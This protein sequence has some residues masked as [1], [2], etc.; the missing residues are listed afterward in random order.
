MLLLN[1]LASLSYAGNQVWKIGHVRPIDSSIDKDIRGLTKEISE[2]TDGQ[3]NFEVYPASKL[4]DYSLV[5]ERCSFGEVEM[6][7]GPF[8][9]T[10]DRRLALPATPYLVKNWSEAKRVFAHDNLLMKKMAVYLEQQNIKLL[11]GWPV[12]FGG[13]LTT[14]KPIELKNPEIKKQILLRVPP[15]N[16]FRWT[17]TA[18][19]YTP[20]PITWVYARSGLESGMVEGV[21]GGGAEGYLGLSKWGKYYLAINDHFEHW[22][23][24]MNLELWQNLTAQQKAI[25]ESSVR[26]MEDRRFQVAE[27]EEKHNLERLQSLGIDVIYFSKEEM[28]DISQRVRKD[29][30]PLLESDFGEDLSDL[31]ETSLR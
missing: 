26:S 28:D 23:V 17:A 31:L 22:L 11:G 10:I 12:Y 30:W 9:T 21:L 24:Y 20:Y 19:G 16:S 5:Q 2:K 25:I 27:A 29:V 18:L 1:L 13:I 7:V 15:I 3:I 6:Y 14:K 4:G 8:G